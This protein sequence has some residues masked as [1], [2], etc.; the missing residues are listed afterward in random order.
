MSSSTE[1]SISDME[2][3][4]PSEGFADGWLPATHL[5]SADNVDKILHLVEAGEDSFKNMNG[6]KFPSSDDCESD[7]NYKLFL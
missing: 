5:N 1:E 7:E 3:M 2:R 6:C 4:E